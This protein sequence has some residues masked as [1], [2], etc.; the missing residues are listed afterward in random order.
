MANRKA[1]VLVSGK[2]KELPSGDT[3][4]GNTVLNTGYSSTT[5]TIAATDTVPAAIS[6]LDGNKA[7]KAAATGTV[8]ALPFNQDSVQGT[9]ASPLT[10]NITLNATGALLGVVVVVIHN[11]GSAPTFTSGVFKKL[12][13]SGNYVTGVIN[14]IWCMYINSTEI[15]YSIQQRT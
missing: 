11:A 4:A 5:G 15:I 9:V 3:L 10:G 7:N 14:Y 1:L 13:G 12:S 8:V 6:K 2:L